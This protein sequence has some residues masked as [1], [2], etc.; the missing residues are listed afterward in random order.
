MVHEADG[1]FL[2]F[3]GYLNLVFVATGII[4]GWY[5]A[6]RIRLTRKY[7]SN[8]L[9]SYGDTQ[10]PY[11]RIAF[12][13]VELEKK[14]SWDWL[15]VQLRDGIVDMECDIVIIYDRQKQLLDP[16]SFVFSML[17]LAIA[18]SFGSKSVKGDKG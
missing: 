16:V 12:P 17:I 18:S 4:W 7:L 5:Y 10:K 8:L 15:L 6:R 2:G 3:P 9:V 1:L 13:V 11:L 14:D